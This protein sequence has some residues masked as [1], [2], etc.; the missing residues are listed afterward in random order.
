MCAVCVF[1]IDSVAIE[2]ESPASLPNGRA[3]SM[4]E[5][6]DTELS[7]LLKEAD[8]ADRCGNMFLFN[9]SLLGYLNRIFAKTG[10]GQT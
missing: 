10:S 9:A 5:R 2:I 6:D 1:R 3:R 8:E 4:A 7:L